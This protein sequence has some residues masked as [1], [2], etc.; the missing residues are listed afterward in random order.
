MGE[1]HS[2]SP[3]SSP[4]EGKERQTDRLIER[5]DNYIYRLSSFFCSVTQPT[6]WSPHIQGGFL[7]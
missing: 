5:E 1:G 4:T 2:C 6:G 3:H 7:L